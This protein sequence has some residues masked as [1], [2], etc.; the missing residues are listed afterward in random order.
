MDHRASLSFVRLLANLRWLAVAGQALTVLSVTRLMG[1]DLIQPPLWGGIAAFALF[2]IYATWFART[3]QDASHGVVFAHLLADIASLAWMV[4]WSGGIENPFS[5]LFVLPMVL[6]ILALPP[7]WAWG[8][9]A[10]SIA[11]YAMAVLA[12][13]EL[14]HVHGMT[15]DAFGL[16]KLGMLVNFAVSALVVLVFFARVAAARRDSEREVARLREQFARDEGILAL[17]THAAWVAHEL[18]TPLGTLTLM[19][20]DLAAQAQS[21]A[22]RE[23][24]ATLKALLEVCRNRVRELAAPARAGAEGGA[25]GVDI[26]RVIDGWQLIRPTIELR[27]SG[28]LEGLQKADAAVGHLLQ[29]LLNNAADAGQQRGV[30][31][32]DLHI[33]PDGPNGL[34]ASI[35]DYGGGFDPDHPVLPGRPFRTSKP[36]GLGIGLVLSHAT[37][38]R[39]GGEL[40]VR[41]AGNGP[42]VTVSFFLPS[43]VRT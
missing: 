22:Q 27:R 13:R 36:D 35:R 28:S 10:A 39:L 24:F 21:D 30:A 31:R 37:V 43:L 14:P 16:H 38:E 33:E 11:G 2:N 34:R 5:S 17:A 7:G 40:S 20:E 8:C 41:P 25:P 26:G 23:E 42:G 9:A 4:G 6:S 1:V 12:G 3:R 15:G 32:V 29:A 19:V 18:N